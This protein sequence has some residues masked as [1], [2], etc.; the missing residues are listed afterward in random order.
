MKNRGKHRIK[1]LLVWLLAAMVAD[2]LITNF[3]VHYGLAREANPF[4]RYWVR[5]DVFLLLKLAIGFL[6][7]VCLRVMYEWDP[8]LATVSAASLLAL[9]IL[10]ILWNI[11]ILV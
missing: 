7:T 9:Y 2:G 1:V 11:S 3:F 6:V 5:T 10:V 4:L 8:R